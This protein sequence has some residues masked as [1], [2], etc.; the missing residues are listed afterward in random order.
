MTVWHTASLQ[1]QT[2]LNNPHWD[3]VL[4]SQADRE[5]GDGGRSFGVAPG[6]IDKRV[7]ELFTDH[8][9]ATCSKLPLVGELNRS[10]ESN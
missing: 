8:L 6:K 2:V 9:D 1:Q 10:W 3:L 5:S 4:P 7:S